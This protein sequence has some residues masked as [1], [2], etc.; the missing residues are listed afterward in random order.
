MIYLV[1]L[2]GKNCAGE[3]LAAALEDGGDGVPPR[4][5]YVVGMSEE[6]ALA[7]ALAD[8]NMRVLEDPDAEEVMQFTYSEMIGTEDERTLAIAKARALQLSHYQVTEKI[9]CNSRSKT[10]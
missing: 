10:P 5:V 3:N 6:S 4:E 8:R 2:L 7:S 1:A 9:R